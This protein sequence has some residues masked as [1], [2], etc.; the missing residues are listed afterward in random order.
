MNRPTVLELAESRGFAID[1]SLD[2]LASV[3]CDVV[4]H[5]FYPSSR[6]AVFADLLRIQQQMR[7]HQQWKAITA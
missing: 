4:L 5:D 2:T 6:R 1:S 3:S 7:N